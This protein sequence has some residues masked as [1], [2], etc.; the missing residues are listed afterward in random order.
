MGG[1]RP[2]PH[3]PSSAATPDINKTKAPTTALGA[4]TVSED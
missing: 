3:S 2:A 4:F 1:T